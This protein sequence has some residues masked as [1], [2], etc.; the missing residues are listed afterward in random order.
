M[1]IMDNNRT[2]KQQRKLRIKAK[3]HGTSERPRLSVFRSN[4][5]LYAQIID[6][7]KGKTLVS[8]IE[9]KIGTKETKATNGTK[10]ERAKELGKQLAAKAKDKKIN[11]VTFDK[12]L[13][14]YHGRIKSFAEG[15]KEGGLNF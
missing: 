10:V 1:T 2:T 12:S 7:T 15:A 5:S 8:I 6:D 13:Y 4:K 9:N 11:K 3:V 14:K